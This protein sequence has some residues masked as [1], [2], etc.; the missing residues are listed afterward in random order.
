MALIK[1]VNDNNEKLSIRNGIGTSIVL[2][3]SNNYFP[4]FAISVLGSTNYQV[5][6]IS[7]LPQFIG[8]FA[9]LIGSVILGRLGEKKKFTAY[10][11]LF[12]RLF[13]LAMFFVIY[14]PSEYRSW[15]FVLL[16]GMM[17]LPGSFA[18]LSWQA[19]IGDIIPE[20]RRN[21]F[22]SE[23]NKIITIVGMVATF[24]MGVLLQQFD[25]SNP[26]PYQILFLF[27]FLVGLLEI[28][29]LNR[30]VEP[31]VE[32]KTNSKSMNMGLNVF[33]H[34]PFLYFLIC[35]LFFNFAWQ[36]S[37]SLFSIYNIKHAGATAFWISLIAVANQVSQVVS[38]KWWGKMADKHSN[39]KM[40]VLVSLGMASAPILTIL[41]T[42]MFYLIVINT[43]SGL[44]VSG[45]V[46]LLFNQLLEVTEDHNRSS[47]I[48][49]YNILLAIV[50]FVAPQFGVYMLETTTMDIAMW[51]S[52]FLRAFSAVFFIALYVYLK[53][54]HFYGGQLQVGHLT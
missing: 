37:W 21:G 52:G 17:N 53:K 9:M 22:F 30:H 54:N 15:V 19:F 29:Y 38:F 35:G 43:F 34:K 28:Y 32:K 50:G 44:F 16:V 24:L 8:M 20:K 23:R 25:K 11:F 14:I 31:P 3:I 51:L 46:L 27:A 39:A 7:S 2:N 10:S 45:T 40:L 42:N 18:N 6:L 33:K 12:T 5:G 26:V 13:L 4:L 48:S 41:S 49:N 47:C 36:M 1:S